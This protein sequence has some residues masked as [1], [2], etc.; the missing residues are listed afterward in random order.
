MKAQ[1]I[2][3]AD[4]F[5]QFE[6]YWHPRIIG[7][8]NG[9]MVKIAKVK[10]DFVMHHHVNEDELFYVVK[11]TLYIETND[12]ILQLNEGDMTIIPRGVDHRPYAPDECHI[13]MFEPASTV[14]TGSKRNDLTHLD[15][16]KI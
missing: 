1:P 12:Q 10:G 6:D 14:N 16:D 7:E 3:L 4:K 2:K 5:A 8:L 11:G 9:Q 13:M 15:L